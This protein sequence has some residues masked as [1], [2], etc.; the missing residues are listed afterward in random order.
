VT[1]A[2]GQR[3]SGFP[4]PDQ[5]YVINHGGRLV[6]V[7]GPG[8]GKTATIVERMMRLLEE[9]AKR[10]LSFVTFSRPSRRDTDSKM[11]KRLGRSSVDVAPDDLP[12]ITTLHAFAK[13]LVHKFADRCGRSPDFRVSAPQEKTIVVSEVID[14]LELEVGLTSLEAAISAARSTG[15]W[16]PDPLLG[17]SR[18]REIM[19]KFDSLLAFYNT[20]DMEGLVLVASELLRNGVGG[21]PQIFLQVDEYQDLNLKDQEL[22][23]LASQQESSQVVVAG[24]DAQSIYGFRHANP[25]GIRDLWHSGGWDTKRFA[26]CHR[27]PAHILRAA[28]AL[29]EGR[30]YL[31]SE[32]TLPAEDRG[33]RVLTLRCSTD[34]LQVKAVAK[35]IEWLLS[36]G[37]SQD[38]AVARGD[39]MILCPTVNQVDRVARELEG[40]G[41]PTK[42]KGSG[43][44]PDA[45]WKLLLVLRILTAPTDGL[46]LRQWLCVIG[47]NN[48]EITGIRREAMQNRRSFYEQ[49]SL[50][51]DEP[52]AAFFASLEELRVALPFPDKFSAVLRTF[53]H[54]DGN[55]EVMG[56]VDELAQYA[57]AALRMIG[58]LYEKYGVV[59]EEGGDQNVPEDDKI[60]VATMHGSKGLEAR[61]VFIMWLNGR[62]I[63]GRNRNEL[64]EERVLYVALTRAKR[65][66]VLVFH[67]VYEDGRRL[68]ER[69]MTPLLRR[70]REHLDIKTVRARDIED[71]AFLSS[72]FPAAD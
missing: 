4:S 35:V 56:V 17:D 44:M 53:P 37:R 27:L 69:A 13:A 19:A 38:G 7:A 34:A 9:D 28:Q 26:E 25:A 10:A 50:K 67:E 45:V 55:K 66:V 70:I 21:L 54:L 41:L 48:A 68:G 52:L 47:F 46:A 60:L 29:I 1:E 24:D 18:R 43:L 58:R 16:P 32:V 22:V 71:A 20:L 40:M 31:G 63:P 62:Y 12:R 72:L 39:F 59:D 30:G 64:E 49:C 42:K 6:L 5:E 65:D 8:T 23:R 11:R 15:E 14:D 2:G 61:F 33:R 51:P 57:P 36:G 3:L